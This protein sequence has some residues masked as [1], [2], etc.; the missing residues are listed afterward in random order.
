[1][2]DSARISPPAH[3]TGDVWFRNGLSYRA[4]RTRKGVVY[5]NALR[6][7]NDAYRI[8][9]GPTLE[10]MLLARH[11]MIDRL[12]ERATEAGEVEQ[13]IEV[14]DGLS[15]R[16]CRFME[17]Y[18]DRIHYVEVDL[19]DMTARKREILERAGS[20]SDRYRLSDI[21]A[22]A[23]SGDASVGEVTRRMLDPTK[24][25]AV[26]TEGL[27]PCFDLDTVLGMWCRFSAALSAFPRGLYL[28]DLHL[29]GETG[30]L[31]GARVFPAL[32]SVFTGDRVHTHFEHV[33]GQCSPSSVGRP[34]QTRLERRSTAMLPLRV[35]H[36]D[37]QL[38]R[39]DPTRRHPEDPHALRARRRA[40][41]GPAAG[42][43]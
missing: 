42:D 28:S 1:M 27:L 7:M 38:H 19:P 36:E 23:G 22:L 4:L 16:G 6:P 34:D 25:T 31:P 20:N 40:P 24:G 14:A 35:R 15:P 13:V 5:F 9:G 33:I 43:P 2:G 30:G 12:L 39:A 32:L 26:I 21:D 29:S 37:H 10:D 41:A 3:Y 18:G 8:A 11:R 17:K